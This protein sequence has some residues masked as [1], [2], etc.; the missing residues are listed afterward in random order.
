[1]SQPAL[2]LTV[3][4]CGPAWTNPGEPCSSYLVEA[5][6][7]RILLDCG[8]G[9]FAAL[10]AL[11][12]RPL[13]AIVLSHLHFDHCG[14]LVPFAYSRMYAGLRGWPPPRLVAPPGG[15]ERLAAL[16]EA[17]GAK[18][19]HLDGPF[20]LEEYQPGTA[21]DI[22]EARLTFAALR[23]PGVSHAIRV[24]SGG[25]ALC[26]SGD[27]GRTPLLAE[28]A[29]GVDLLLCE[30][31]QGDAAESDEV[32]LSASD[33]GAAAAAAD[34]GQLLLV[35]VD[36]DRRARAVAA[37]QETFRGPVEAGVPGFRVALF[38]S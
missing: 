33:A 18:R 11:D 29:R 16:A 22:G 28:H 23:H 4:G 27:T 35:H 12:P 34:V 10:Q 20:S 17:G 15:L 1:L 38:A 14:D 31:T 30:S 21:L 3:V 19:D 2:T 6:L 9:A 8:S 25:R 36:A 7:T 13:D 32:H 24:E 26:F 5:G 37:A